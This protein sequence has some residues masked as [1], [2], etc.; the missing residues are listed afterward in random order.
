ME[1]RVFSTAPKKPASA[2]FFFFCQLFGFAPPKKEEA[3]TSIK[4][5]SGD[6]DLF[7]LGS[8]GC[9]FQGVRLSILPPFG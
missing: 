5:A 7:R 3:V 9:K 8:P 2:G 4:Y 6:F 1:V